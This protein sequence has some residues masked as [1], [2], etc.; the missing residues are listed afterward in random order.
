MSKKQ[1]RKHLSCEFHEGGAFCLFLF[2]YFIGGVCM[3]LVFVN[4]FEKRVE[5]DRVV[6]AQVTIGERQGV[7]CVMWN[8]PG[9]DGKTAQDC[10]F[11][12]DKWQDMMTAF[13]L[14]LAEKT[15]AGFLP[16]VEGH[17]EGIDAPSAKTKYA[18]MLHY[19]SECHSNEELFQQLR[20]WR[21][22]QAIKENKPS[23]IVATN[24]VLRMISCYVP[25]NNEELKC[26]PGL[27]EN[28]CNLYG[29]SITDIT[30]KHSR[31]GTFPLEWVIQQIDLYEFKLWVHKQREIKV[32]AELERQA[33]KK[34]MLE[35]IARGESLE[36]LQQTLSLPRREIVL[37]TEELET[38]GYDLD[39]FIDG[40]LQNV[41][42]ADQE[43]AWKAFETEG[44]RY[45]KPVLKKIYNEEEIKD[46]DLDLTYEWLRLLRMR[47][48]K[49]KASETK[50]S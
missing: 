41:P 35:L 29:N 14:K 39:T 2:F 19:Y 12:G 10:W 1:T 42:T 22:E 36:S 23:Y 47:Y 21:R 32:K 33:T 20:L 15:A 46:K 30:K 28:K 43:M 9:P 7:W 18:Q 44:D 11:E 45:L 4:S 16:L 37:W 5:E 25:H 13:R 24:R 48:R 26:I 50:V 17:L 49:E 34:K 38:E 8:E 27:G 6:T 3:N 40:E 31:T